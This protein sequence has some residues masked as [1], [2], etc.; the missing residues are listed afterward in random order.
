MPGIGE[1]TANKTEEKKNPALWHAH[2]RREAFTVCISSVIPYNKPEVRHCFCTHFT[3]REKESQNQF[4]VP[5]P[6]P[7]RK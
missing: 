4:T 1:V 2:S 6:S 3:D 7:S 5:F